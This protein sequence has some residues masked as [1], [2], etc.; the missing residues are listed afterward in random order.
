MRSDLY[1]QIRRLLKYAGTEV[2]EIYNTEDGVVADV[3]FGRKNF[4]LFVVPKT[5][6]NTKEKNI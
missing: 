2:V 6:L 1:D 5:K 3:K 4:R